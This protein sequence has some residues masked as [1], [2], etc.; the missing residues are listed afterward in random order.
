VP[1][2]EVL[3]YLARAI[4]HNGRDLEGAINRLLAHSSSTTGR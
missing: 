2:E 3:T 1:P 4:T